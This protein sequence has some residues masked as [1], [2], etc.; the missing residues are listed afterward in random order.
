MGDEIL[1]RFRWSF[2]TK[3]CGQYISGECSLKDDTLILLSLDKILR[4]YV[5]P[6]S[7]LIGVKSGSNALKWAEIVLE[8]RKP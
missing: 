5:C 8:E 2:T 4:I 7:L 3:N 1:K 6:P